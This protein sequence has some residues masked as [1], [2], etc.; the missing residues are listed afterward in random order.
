MRDNFTS[1]RNLVAIF[2]FVGWFVIIGWVG[3]FAFMSMEAGLLR[4]AIL[5]MPFILAGAMFL[6]FTEIA[7]AVIV[8]AEN[9]Q[10]IHAEIAAIRATASSTIPREVVAPIRARSSIKSVVASGDI[11][12]RI[13]PAE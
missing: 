8:T 11:G 4:A 3:I 10:A 2:Q 6:L 13:D 7:R 9:A 12:G 5:A 1:G